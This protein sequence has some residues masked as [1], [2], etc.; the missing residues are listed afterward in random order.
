MANKPHVNSEGQKELEK[1]E[2][3]FDEYKSQVDSLL[4]ARSPTAEKQELQISQ[5]DTENSKDVY[6]KPV[7]AIMSREKFNEKFREQYNRAKEYVHYIA[8][9]NEVLGETIEMWT[10]PFPGLPAE[11]WQIPVNKPV[12][13]PRYVQEKLEH[14]CSYRRLKTEDKV[15]GNDGWG[16]YTGQ[17][18]IDTVIARLTAQPVTTR[19][20]ISL[21]YNQAR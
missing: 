17:I 9:N 13:M 12:W 15:V 21:R 6:L 11:F 2:K 4:D 3:Q 7:R 5:K 19:K 16:K 1:V 10:K 18:V 20:N 14:G 8:I